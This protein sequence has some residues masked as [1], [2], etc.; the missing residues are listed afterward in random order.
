MVDEEIDS[1]CRD[2][3]PMQ[4]KPN[5]GFVQMDQ[6]QRQTLLCFVVEFL[7]SEDTPT[8][9]GTLIEIDRG[10]DCSVEASGVDYD[11]KSKKL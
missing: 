9:K 4:G 8:G 7:D 5:W 2:L 1:N 3:G 11:V 10:G 6:P